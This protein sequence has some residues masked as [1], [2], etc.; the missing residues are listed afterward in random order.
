MAWNAETSDE[1]LMLLYRQGE[2]G[3]FECGIVVLV[4]I[5]EADD[6][7]ASIQQQLGS[8]KADKTGG[9]GNQY[10]HA[11]F[12]WTELRVGRSR[13]PSATRA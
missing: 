13:L 3:A 10:L 7:V 9:S 5:V 8:M 12:L 2:A 1:E 4:E 6:F 11:C